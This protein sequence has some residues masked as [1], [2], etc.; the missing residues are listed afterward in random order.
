[1]QGRLSKKENTKIIQEYLK[2]GKKK[3]L[4]D[5]LKFDYLEYIILEKN[6]NDLPIF[7]KKYFNFLINK[8]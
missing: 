6:F 8:N 5:I 1:M 3:I 2:I 7:S 4:A